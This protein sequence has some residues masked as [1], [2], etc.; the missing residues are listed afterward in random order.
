MERR[1]RGLRPSRAVRPAAALATI[2]L[3]LGAWGTT[4][5]AGSETPPPGPPWTQDF[6]EAQ[7]RALSAGKTH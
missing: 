3:V 5:R 6:G 4:G 1:R 2:C 7:A